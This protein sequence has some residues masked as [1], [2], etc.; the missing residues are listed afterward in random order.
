[1]AG[2]AITIAAVAVSL[3]PM[4]ASSGTGNVREVRLVVRDMTYYL[5][6]STE[7]NPTLQFRAGEQVRLVLKNDDPGMDHDFVIPAWD[8]RTKL[9]EGR[10]EDM[11]LVKVPDTRGTETYQCTP[12]SGMMRGSIR[13]E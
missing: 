11:V 10:G 6:G 5:D 9:L 7:P 12:H 1:M 2:I 4:L 8:T 3:L 13:V